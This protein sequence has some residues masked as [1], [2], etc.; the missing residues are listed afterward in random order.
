MNNERQ[1]WH[2]TVEP[3]LAEPAREVSEEFLFIENHFHR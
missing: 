2:M 3:L 1:R